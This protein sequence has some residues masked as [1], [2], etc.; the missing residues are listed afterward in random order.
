MIFSILNFHMTFFVNSFLVSFGII[1]GLGDD[2]IQAAKKWTAA[3]NTAKTL[4]DMFH[5]VIRIEMFC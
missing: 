4:G 3:Q 5:W 2:E 1:R